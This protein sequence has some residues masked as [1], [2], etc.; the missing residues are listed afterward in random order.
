M[1]DEGNTVR[2]DWSISRR[3]LLAGAA[4]ASAMGLLPVTRPA[5]AQDKMARETESVAFTTELAR[6]IAKTPGDSIPESSLGYA[7]IILLDTVGVGVAGMQTPTVGKLSQIDPSYG[8][9]FISHVPDIR[10]PHV[11][12]PRAIARAYAA[13]N[14]I[15][16]AP[17]SNPTPQW[18][19]SSIFSLVLDAVP[20][21]LPRASDAARIGPSPLPP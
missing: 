7:K 1:T 4:V 17:S 16:S 10:M 9:R 14:S 21:V 20:T 13:P 11:V 3:S 12:P 19:G 6:F 2:D 15:S 5:W 18:T 8:T